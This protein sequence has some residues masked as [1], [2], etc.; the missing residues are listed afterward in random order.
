MAIITNTGLM[1][2]LAKTIAQAVTEPQLVPDS[3]NEQGTTVY[4]MT[5]VD[6]CAHS[7]NRATHCSLLSFVTIN[8]K[9][10]FVTK[11]TLSFNRVQI[12]TRTTLCGNATVQEQFHSYLI[13]SFS[14]TLDFYSLWELF[15]PSRLAK[16]RSL[17][18]MTQNLSLL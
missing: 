7:M 15:W 8:T 12:Y 4:I 14:S 6:N 2:I 13:L 9:D 11:I 16:S 3:E 17:S 18:S 10:Y 1:L 5:S